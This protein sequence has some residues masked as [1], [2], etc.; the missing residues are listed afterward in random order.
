MVKHAEESIDNKDL[1][2][3]LKIDTEL[4]QSSI[5]EGTLSLVKEFEP[6]GIGNTEP[7]FLTERL[8]VLESRTVG[9]GGKH[10][11]ML[12][13][14]ESKVFDAI[15]FSS[16][17]DCPAAGSFIDAVYNLSED[18]WHGDNRLQLKIKDFRNSSVV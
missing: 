16:E 4:D 6:F 13:G 7:T 3:T 17:K 11:K 9:A 5:N 12:L 15:C 14:A 18:T 10:I 8:K 1:I 2:P